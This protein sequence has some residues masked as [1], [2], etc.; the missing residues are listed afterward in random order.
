MPIEFSLPDMMGRPS[1]EKSDTIAF[2][3]SDSNTP[4]ASTHVSRPPR[5]QPRL[6]FSICRAART[7]TTGKLGSKF[8]AVAVILFLLCFF[9]SRSWGPSDIESVQ[10]QEG[11]V[12]LYEEAIHDG[13]HITLD[14]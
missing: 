7:S 2:G 13:T 8:C 4:T 10:F 12:V 1:D 11:E 9:R 14:C 3:G 6:P 5:P